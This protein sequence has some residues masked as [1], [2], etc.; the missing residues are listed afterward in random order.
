MFPADGVHHLDR[1]VKVHRHHGGG[2]GEAGHSRQHQAEAVEEGD[3]HAEPVLFGELHAVADALA[4]VEDVVVGEHH[5]LGEAGGAGGVLHIDDLVAVQPLPDLPEGLVGDRRPVLFQPGPG[6]HPGGAVPGSGIDDLVQEGEHGVQM[7]PLFPQPPAKLP[8]D[9]HIAGALVLVDHHQHLGVR[10]LEEV[11]QLEHLVG[12]VH[13]HQ[14]RPDLAGGKEGEE[15]FRDVGGPDRDLV[16]LL[17]P[18]GQKAL[19][20]AV[21]L[22]VE[23]LPGAAVGAVGVDHG[24]PVREPP[25]H[26]LQL[27]PYRVGHKSFHRNSLLKLKWVGCA[28]R[29]SKKA[30]APWDDQKAKAEN[31]RGTTSVDGEIPARSSGSDN[32]SSR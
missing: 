13:R 7:L 10:L 8:D 32:P 11:L 5:P 16:P 12:G 18:V 29:G 20:D 19:G 27:P 17:D 28:P 14:H 22:V 9:L 30:S 6:G 1:G 3:H 2:V 4:V 26:Q 25:G 31:S 23:L 21:A 24:L 15:P